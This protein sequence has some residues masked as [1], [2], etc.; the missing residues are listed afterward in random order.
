MG[1][2]CRRK[3]SAATS[4]VIIMLAHCAAFAEP[5]NLADARKVADTFL[6]VQPADRAGTLAAAAETA[7]AP[8][9]YRE[10]R[11]SNGVIVAYVADLEPRGFIAVAANTDVTPV[12]AYSLRS[13]FPAAGD[14]KHPLG[15]M[16]RADLAL[17]AKALAEDP[18]I[19]NPEVGRLWDLYLAGQAEGLGDAAFQQW[20]P[21]GT[22]STGGWV[23]TTWEQDPP[24]NSFCPLD[25]VDGQR[26]YVGCV[27]TALAQILH[28]HR[29]FDMSFGP[30]DSYVTYSGIWLDAD[31]DLYDFPSFAELNTYLDA[32]RLKCRDGVAL[33]E[34]DMAALSLACGIAVGMDYSSEGSGASVYAV[35]DALLDRLGFHSADLFGGISRASHL[36]LQENLVNGSP[37]LVS[38]SPPDGFGG[39]ALVCDGYNTRGEYHLNFGWG[40]SH[41]TEISEAWYCLPVDIPSSASVITETILNLRPDEPLIEVDPDALDFYSLPSQ[42]S[43]P[44][45]VRIN[46]RGA[47]ALI[48]SI[49]SADGFVISGEDGVYADRIDSFTIEN[50]SEGAVVCVRFRPEQAGG[51]YGTL[52]IGYNNGNCRHVVLRGWAFEGGTNV[53]AGNV[54]GTWTDSEGPYFVT[55]DIKVPQDRELT[56]Q[57]G[58]K[59]FF[60]GRYGMTVGR[61]A[62]L[63]AQGNAARPIE[64]TA[65]NREDGWAGLRF[66]DSDDDD[67]L[68]HC[69]ITFANKGADPIPHTDEPADTTPDS[70]GGALYCSESS[71]TIENCTIANNTGDIGG[72]IYCDTGD[73]VITNTVIANNASLGGWSRCGGL[74]FAGSSRPQVINCTIVNN[75]PGGIFSTSWLPP[76]VVNTIVWGNDDYQ[77]QTDESV[78]EVTFSDVQSGYHGEGNMDLDPRFL[79]PSAGVGVDY[80]GT[81]A[82]W[83]LRDFSPCVNAGTQVE[84]LPETDPTGGPRMYCGIVDLGACE[85]QA[86]GPSLT[87]RPSVT[88]DVGFVP[89]GANTT[90]YFDLLNAGQAGFTVQTI[91][92]SDANEVFSMGTTAEGVYLSP[93]DSIRVEV[94]FHPTAE[95]VYTGVVDIRSGGRNALHQRVTL[96]GVGVSGTIIP[97]GPVSGTWKRADGPYTVTGDIEVPK[98]QTLTIEPGVVVRFAGHFRLTVGYRATLRAVGTEQDKITFTATDAHEGWFGIRFYSSG[99]DDTL[100]HCILEHAK[101]P[102]EGGADIPDLF[103]G[104]VFCG[105]F[106]NEWAALFTYSSPLIDSCLFRDNYGRTGGAIA[107]I[108]G[109]EATITN[110]T[111]IGNEADYDGGAITMY[112]ADCTIGNNVIARNSAWVAGGIMNYLG[113][114]TIVNNTIVSNRPSAMHLELTTTSWVIRQR[115]LITNNVVWSNEIFATEDVLPEEYDICFNDIQGGWEGQGNIDIDPAFVDPPNDDY[116]LKSQAGHW[117]SAQGT[118]VTDDVTSPCID[119]GDP[120]A[121]VGDEPPLNGSRINMGAYGGTTQASKTP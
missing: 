117:D 66:I 102:R 81:S 12:V 36:T 33:D 56:I 43:A 18:Q 2:C 39:H 23:E 68:S 75:L 7:A 26:S 110:N 95:R 8:V 90:T 21:E 64:F 10:I 52:R 78:M 29:Q 98:G 53:P 59:V 58:V 76:T 115:C 103:G 85:S 55:G 57:P 11:D 3:W 114:P 4:I 91:S 67:V 111:F 61:R 105:T 60:T 49:S 46:N 17:R 30:D 9:G 31:N 6:R 119:A 69:V 96:R 83:A 19:K 74:H 25:P 71:P 20:P 70:L 14:T 104:A 37:A 92:L 50:P 42:E 51:F 65:W 38:I 86:E 84:G 16:L 72:A 121:D 108:D 106:G 47:N 40:G 62:R 44:Q 27:A 80:D 77:I 54:S 87:V 99:T 5:V 63:V 94:E 113:V 32:V 107:C 120:G 93:G 116:H 79:D 13:S 24:Y 1:R 35:R 89:A 28:Y 48:D 88:Q 82:N 118:W 15:R 22:T 100:Q 73:P 34:T 101:K 112:Y 109:S 41:P 45:A 97:G